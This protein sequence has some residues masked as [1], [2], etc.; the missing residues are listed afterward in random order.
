MLTKINCPHGQDK[1][2]AWPIVFD[3]ELTCTAQFL[4]PR[5]F[6]AVRR[7]GFAKGSKPLGE[8]GQYEKLALVGIIPEWTL[9]SFGII[10]HISLQ[11]VKPALMFLV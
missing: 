5:N 9:S 3:T 11:N 6:I 8:T 4:Y 2:L 10:L 7:C 1:R